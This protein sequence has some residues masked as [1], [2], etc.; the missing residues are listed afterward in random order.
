MARPSTL[1]IRGVATG[2]TGT[3]D[4]YAKLIVNLRDITTAMLA[5]RASI[6]TRTRVVGKLNG[7]KVVCYERDSAESIV[8]RYR[9]ATSNSFLTRMKVKLVLTLDWLLS[10]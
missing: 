6:E 10:R 5:A 2:E 4:E 7:V 9:L 8:A 1:K 3:I